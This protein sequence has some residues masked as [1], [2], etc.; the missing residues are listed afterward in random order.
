M[1]DSAAWQRYFIATRSVG[2]KSGG[3]M[4]GILAKGSD[5]RPGVAIEIVARN[6]DEGDQILCV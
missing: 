3:E 6:V 2:P 5:G 1:L 4:G